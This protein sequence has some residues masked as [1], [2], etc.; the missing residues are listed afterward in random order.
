MCGIVGAI[1]AKDAAPLI[2]AGLLALQHRGQDSAGMLTS[3][4]QQTYAKK[5]TGLVSSIF[6]SGLEQLKGSMGIGHT[7]YATAGSS[8]D[9]DTQPFHLDGKLQIAISHNG[10]IVNTEELK[11]QVNGKMRSTADTEL[12]LHIFSEYLHNGN[13]QASFVEQIFAAVGHIM[14]AVKG[15]YSIV[16]MV[17]GHGMLAFRDPLG[18]KPLL[19]GSRNNSY[20]FCS[21]TVALDAIGYALHS[22]LQP[23]EA[24]FA[25]NTGQLYRRQIGQDKHAPCMFEWVYF[26]RPD[27]THE[28]RSVYA[29]REELGRLL[30]RQWRKTGR[31]LDVAI[32]VPDT[33]RPA[34]SGFAEEL[35]IALREGLIKN[36]YVGRTFIMP[37]QVKRAAAVQLNLNPIRPTIEGKRV[38]VIDDSIV[39][40]TTSKRIVQIVRA[41]GAKEVHF[42]VTCP[43]I[44]WPCFYGIDMSTRAELIAA[45]K[46]V[47]DIRQFIGADTLTYQTLDGLQQAIGRT[48]LCSACLTGAYPTGIN[49]GDIERLE[50][51]RST[52]R[53]ANC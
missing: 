22:Q 1:N 23:G 25:D 5:G 3:D 21:E 13:G 32:P 8:F 26:A 40:G 27:S 36:R 10:N 16:M 17:Q 38:A 7:R 39:R 18:I 47:E 42:F 43:P 49:A 30:A 14:Q 45:G 37:S 33:S 9:L 20:V 19:I 28:E 50:G 15:S 46:S 11:G 51:R 48:A 2:Y 6:A 24:A 44:K 41:A 34:A 31:Q 29:A 35:G 53:A 52:E 4:G 12:I